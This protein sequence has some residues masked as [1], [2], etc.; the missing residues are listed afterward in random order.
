MWPVI[1]CH[2]EGA[3]KSLNVSTADGN[4][5][6]KSNDAEKEEAVRIFLELVNRFDEHM[7]KHKKNVEADKITI[8]SQYRAQ[9][10]A[11]EQDLKARGYAH[12]NVNTVI[13]SQGDEW[14]YVILSLVRSMP[15]Y[16]IEKFPSIGWCKR[17]MGFIT[18]EHQINVALTR[19]RLGLIIIG[20]KHLLRCNSMWQ[21][22]LNHCSGKL[23]IVNANQFLPSRNRITQQA[24]R[25]ILPFVR[26]PS[27]MSHQLPARF[28]RQQQSSYQTLQRAATLR[29]GEYQRQQQQHQ[30]QHRK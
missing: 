5:Q 27:L 22:L 11:I 21:E 18:D 15:Q 13:A 20:N 8:L 10:S 30:R 7:N 4:E 6:S 26:Q 24:E 16:E 28:Q 9:C 1:F 25:G 14:D 3:E 19:A 23:S 29:E 17:N 12:P 2:V